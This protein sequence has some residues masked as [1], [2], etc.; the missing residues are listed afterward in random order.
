[1]LN[2][3]C[4]QTILL[5]ESD[6]DSDGEQSI[7]EEDLK[8]LL[9]I[10]RCRRKY[11]KQYHS[12]ILVR[13]HFPTFNV[14]VLCAFKI[15]K[16]SQNASGCKSVSEEDV[17]AVAGVS[18]SCVRACSGRRITSAFSALVDLQTVTPIIEK[19]GKQLGVRKNIESYNLVLSV[20]CCYQD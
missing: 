17:L 20:S 9:K 18:C 12:D 14:S 6:S 3:L 19:I 5:E 2:F 10:H 7:K 4:L 16:Q 1:M 13:T 15:T 11:Q 8:S